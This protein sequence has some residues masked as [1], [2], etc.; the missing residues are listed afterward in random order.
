MVIQYFYS[1]ITFLVNNVSSGSMVMFIC[2][3]EMK[4][5]QDMVMKSGTVL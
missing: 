4:I 1:V 2:K 5:G 3:A